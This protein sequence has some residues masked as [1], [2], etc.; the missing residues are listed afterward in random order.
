MYKGL[1]KYYDRLMVDYPHKRIVNFLSAKT[2]LKGKKVLD[3]CT[4]T[5]SGALTLNAVGAKVTGMDVS[6][7][8]LNLASQKVHA[9]AA[10]ITLIR[11]DINR[12]DIDKRFDVITA[13]CD[14][15]NYLSH[16]AAL[17]TLEKIYELLPAGG[18]LFFDITSSYYF[19]NVLNGQPYY[20]DRDTVTY[21]YI[22]KLSKDNK[23][24]TT[25]ISIFERQENGLYQRQDDRSVRYVYEV[26]EM[27]AMLNEVGF[28]VE[29]YDADDFNEPHQNTGRLL[30]YAV[31]GD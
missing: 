29:C 17:E 2:P 3:L 11:G 7:D 16:T 22:N 10:P 31:K 21:F 18:V 1:S 24:C 12:L 9:A 4:G 15:I 26:K 19:V 13:F 8:M 20:E 14:G 30:F 28:T 5:A 27:T 6:T 23:R 25:D